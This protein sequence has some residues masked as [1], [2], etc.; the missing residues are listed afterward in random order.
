[1]HYTISEETHTC[2]MHNTNWYRITLLP[3]PP[4]W[5]GKQIWYAE[6]Y[7][8]THAT[9]LYKYNLYMWQSAKSIAFQTT[10]CKT[11]WATT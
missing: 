2:T 6:E 3:H 5:N 8:N 7:V 4:V 1:M 11:A 10:G 9:P